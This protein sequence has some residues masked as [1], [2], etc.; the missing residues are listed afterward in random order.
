MMRLNTSVPVT[1]PA[2]QMRLGVLAN[3][4]AGYPNGRRPGADVVD[5]VLRTAMGAL[6][7]AGLLS[8][9]EEGTRRLYTTDRDSLREVFQGLDE[10]WSLGLLRLQRAAERRRRR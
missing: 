9:R 4:L 3:D 2:Q 1:P 6:L 5:I 8:V 10:Y 7:D